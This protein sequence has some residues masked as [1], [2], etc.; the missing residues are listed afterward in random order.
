MFYLVA[1]CAQKPEPKDI[2]FLIGQN[3]E[4]CVLVRDFMTDPAKINMDVKTRTVPGVE[5]LRI[6][7]WLYA[8]RMTNGDTELE[9]PHLT[10]VA[11]QN[12]TLELH[13]TEHTKQRFKFQHDDNEAA[14]IAAFGEGLDY[15]EMEQHITNTGNGL[16][17]LRD[18]DMQEFSN[19]IAAGERATFKVVE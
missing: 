6:K 16:I 3:P 14:M 12:K 8:V 18:I 5:D 10:V 17:I 2:W 1:L 19:V 7:P 9:F 11:V 4:L 13:E 15:S